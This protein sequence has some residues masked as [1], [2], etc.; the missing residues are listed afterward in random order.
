[1]KISYRRA[2]NT[3][4]AKPLFVVINQFDTDSFPVPVRHLRLGQTT[5]SEAALEASRLE[6]QGVPELPW[7][8]AGEDEP[9]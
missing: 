9:G 3:R 5:A 7:P 6:R 1:M 4:H 2:G 8:T